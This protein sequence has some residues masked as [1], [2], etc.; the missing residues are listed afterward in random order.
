MRSSVKVYGD[1]A[2]FFVC[3]HKG[4]VIPKPNFKFRRG[5]ADILHFLQ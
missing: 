4:F 3:F 2:S 1:F 5:G